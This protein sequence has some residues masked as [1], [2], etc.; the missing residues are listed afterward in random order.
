[1][2]CQSFQNKIDEAAVSDDVLRHL[3][4]CAGCKTFREE[5]ECLRVL[6]EKL[7]IVSAPANFEFGV[8]AKINS[9]PAK[10]GN[11]VWS[12]RFAFAAPA[13][14]A[15]A[16][17][18]FVL[19]DFR[20]SSPATE[21]ATVVAQQTTV[22]RT[23]QPPISVIENSDFAPSQPSNT[24]IAIAA[25]SQGLPVVSP[26]RN[27]ASTTRG[28]SSPQIRRSE[29]KTDENEV[30]GRDVSEPVK[31]RDLALSPKQPSLNPSGIPNNPTQKIAAREALSFFGIDISADG[32][33]Q[34]VKSNGSASENGVR[35]GDRI[36]TVNGKKM[37]DATLENPLRQVTIEVSRDDQ[38]RTVT[39]SLKNNLPK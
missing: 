12:R 11:R 38:K 36:E 26:S 30:M 32:T 9:A 22:A 20:N 25:P 33:V 31:T 15:V 2:N 17:S 37:A 35:A 13:L 8:R 18:T 23:E 34:S 1:M 21:P 10:S 4:S 19:S 16:I 7:E 5:R 3:E 14:A 27:V 28:V 24:G 6:I 29:I 39:M